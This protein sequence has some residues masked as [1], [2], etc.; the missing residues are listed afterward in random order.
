MFR[1]L[2]APV[3][4]ACSTS[5]KGQQIARS[6]RFILFPTTV[7][8]RS[9]ASVTTNDA[10]EQAVKNAIVA[11]AA[12]EKEMNLS[13]DLDEEKW[14]Q[15][16]SLWKDDS[17]IFIRPSGNPLTLDSMKAMFQSGVATITKHDLVDVDTVKVV[18]GGL[19]AVATYRMHSIFTYNGTENNDVA[20]F[21]SV[22]ENVDGQWKFVH[23]HRATGQAPQ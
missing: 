6:T 11:F 16:L 17:C 18:A 15:Y 7:Q 21:S 2:I 1:R 22:L 19:A 9:M 20:K 23:S 12:L 3:S 4:S 8:K 5:Q 13:K 10:A 14:K